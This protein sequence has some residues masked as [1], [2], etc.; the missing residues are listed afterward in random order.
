MA[1]RW[2]HTSFI[3]ALGG[4]SSDF[5]ASLV[6]KASSR[7]ARTVIEKP[8]LENP[9]KKR[10]TKQK[11]INI[12]NI[13]IK[14]NKGISRKNIFKMTKDKENDYFV[15]M[16]KQFITLRKNSMIK[17]RGLIRNKRKEQVKILKEKL[18]FK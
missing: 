12:Q 6:Y 1:G 5:E 8:C 14:R 10:K 17:G 13:N 9:K 2:W 7:I 4:N 11:H 15:N 3:P 18:L 16:K